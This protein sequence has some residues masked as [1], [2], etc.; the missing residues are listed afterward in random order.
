MPG[1][2]TAQ[3][4]EA[5][6]PAE[7]GF[8]ELRWL[9]T[10]PPL[11]D[12]TSGAYPAAVQAFDASEAQAISRWLGEIER[13]PEALSAFVAN[14]SVSLRIGR[15]AERLIEFFLRQGPTHR[16]AAANL[17]LRHTDPHGD[18]TTVGEIDFLLHDSA[19]R[20]WHWELAVKFFLCMASG[21]QATPCDF[22]GPDAAETLDSKL[23]KLFDRQ[24]RHRPPAPWDGVAWTPAACTRG[25]L[26]YP[27]D[28]RRDRPL[29]VMA[30]LN[31]DHLHGRWVPR[32]RISELPDAAETVWHQVP[33]N[34]WMCPR[35]AD[36]EGQ[37]LATLCAVIEQPHAGVGP[38]AEASPV[39]PRAAISTQRVHRPMATLVQRSVNPD[40]SGPCA[41]ELLFVVP[42]AWPGRPEADRLIGERLTAEG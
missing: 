15:R 12:P 25:R 2:F 28:W 35:P 39:M 8:R 23:H 6:T 14:G 20:P 38:A 31:P 18:C 33:R 32:A 17:P 21:E 16:L 36:G 11:L 1:R 26:F 9:L 27:H 24:L 7:Q 10:S 5:S 4:I 22:V 19:G 42:V 37:D 34:D 40:G 13:A 30:G 41:A 3:A 29:P